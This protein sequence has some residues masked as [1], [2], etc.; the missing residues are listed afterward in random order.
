[1]LDATKIC[2]LGTNGQ[3]GKALQAQYPGAAALDSDNLDITD[4]QAVQS[5][6]WSRF[7]IVINAAAYTNV[8]GAETAEG[9]IAAWNVNAAAV[10]NLTYAF[11]QHK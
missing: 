7:E 4:T 9:R 10:K 11:R 5:F 6:D 1:M 3:L 2:I 8:D